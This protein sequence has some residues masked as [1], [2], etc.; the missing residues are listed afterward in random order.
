[1]EEFKRSAALH[2]V[3]TVR[4]G[5]RVGLGTGSTVRYAIE[6]I[7][8]LVAEGL[9][10]VGVATSRDTERRAARAGIPLEELDERPLD[11]T[12]DGAD[13]VDPEMNLIKGGGGALLREKM[14]ARASRRE[15]I[16]VDHTKMVEAFTFPLPVEVVPYGWKSTRAHL[17]ALGFR[18][19]LRRSVVTDNGNYILDC[20]YHRLENPAETEIELN[21]IP[22]VVDNGLFIDLATEVVVGTPSGAKTI[23]RQ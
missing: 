10:I 22:G 8:E 15:I 4:D 12:I 21:S 16:V 20:S 5:M 23:R 17:S 7:G 13:Q 6:K 18:P 11:L 19:E 3:T 9:D 1:M 2:A 14:V